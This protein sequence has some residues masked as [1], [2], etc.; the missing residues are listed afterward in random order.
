MLWVPLTFTHSAKRFAGSEESWY[1][2]MGHF[3][4]DRSR[5]VRPWVV[6]VS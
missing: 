5:A 2:I 4:R 6:L 1:R 3:F